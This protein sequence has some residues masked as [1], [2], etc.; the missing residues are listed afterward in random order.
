MTDHSTL[1]MHREEVRVSDKEM[2]K[3]ILDRCHTVVVGLHDEPYPY[4]VPRNLW[5]EWMTN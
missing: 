3:A 4:V 5:Y 2:L 1:K